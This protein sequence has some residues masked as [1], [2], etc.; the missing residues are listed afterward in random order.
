MGTIAKVTAGGA[1][2]LIASSAYGECTTAAATAAKTVNITGDG[3]AT[4]PFTLLKGTTIHIKFSNA[5]TA[6]SPTLNVNSTGAK[7]IT[8][9][10]TTSPTAGVGTGVNTW[11]AGALI[12]FTYDGTSWVMNDRPSYH[13]SPNTL[14][15]SQVNSDGSVRVYNYAGDRQFDLLETVN[16]FTGK[17]TANQTPGFGDTFTISQISQS[18]NG[19]VSGTDRTVKIPNTLAS[20]SAN[21]L[22]S[23]GNK[24]AI[25]NLGVLRYETATIAAN[26][27]EVTV[28]GE[29]R[30][31]FV[32]AYQGGNEV[33]V[34][35]TFTPSTGAGN[36]GALK[37]S[38]AENAASPIHISYLCWRAKTASA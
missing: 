20:S 24:V 18:T 16:S 10:G 3:T 12:S 31:E 17:P 32:F 28:S 7:P 34:D 36:T 30:P 23:A 1:T 2:H 19:Q 6:A 26:T 29:T 22:M 27:K 8:K 4:I 13:I 9:Y 38:V 21:G 37:F 35:V 15:Y 25:D 14:E 33:I 11:E 5:N